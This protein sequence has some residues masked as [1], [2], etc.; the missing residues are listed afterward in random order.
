[1][2]GKA[3]KFHSPAVGVD[4][5]GD[6]SVTQSYL[7]LPPG[8]EALNK[9][10]VRGSRKAACGLDNSSFLTIDFFKALQ[11]KNV[12]NEIY[13]KSPPYSH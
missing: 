9:A 13:K 5:L 11:C 4:V 6:T 1:M 10:V 12:E 8:G 2:V 7:R 3:D